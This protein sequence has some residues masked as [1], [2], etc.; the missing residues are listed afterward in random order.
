M[1]K[2]IL[3]ASGSIPKL[4]NKQRFAVEL[5]IEKGYYEYP[6][7]ISVQELAKI[8][9]SPR[10]TFQEHLRKAESKLMKILLQSQNWPS[11][12]CIN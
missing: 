9:K 8:S 10:S 2:I 4:T 7:K 1:K 12:D 11:Y 5:A 6:R 3:S